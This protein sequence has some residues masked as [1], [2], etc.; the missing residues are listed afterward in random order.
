MA[1]Q[2]QR[3]VSAQQER[4]RRR[5]LAKHLRE[6]HGLI[7]ADELTE[8]GFG[9][10]AIATLVRRGEL[11]RI[12]PRVYRSY[13]VPRT[14]GG[15]L[16][17]ALLS[18]PAA[19]AAVRASSAHHLGFLEM[20]PNRPQIGGNL[21]RAGAVRR[22]RWFDVHDLGRVGEDDLDEHDGVM[23]TSPE[24]TALDLGRTARSEG[25][26]RAAATAL[27][28]AARE[29]AD[30]PARLT[31]RLKREPRVPGN[32]QVRML[33][34]DLPGSLLVRSPLEVDFPAFCR[35]HGIPLP[36]MNR[37][38][39]GL[40]LDAAWLLARLAVELDTRAYH[41]DELAFERDRERDGQL[42]EV[43][44]RVLRVTKS[45]LLTNP[46]G[47]ARRILMLLAQAP[48]PAMRAERP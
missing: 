33:L 43:G 20:P 30:L 32:A 36:E 37:R 18:S 35:Q 41:G 21:R 1:T 39:D 24:R 34:G 42:L 17:A 23:C 40:E 38:V 11:E 4:D 3:T 19:L 29:D 13:A 2:Q 8:L 15:T 12:A 14:A 7:T 27:R 48:P 5:R 6:H 26:L 9:R 47:V 28:A 16:R 45:Q 22:H 31:E 25:Q 46:E 10:N 44:W